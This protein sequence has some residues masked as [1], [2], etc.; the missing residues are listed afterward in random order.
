MEGQYRNFQ[1]IL[2]EELEQIE[3]SF[4]EERTELIDSN[5][6]EIESL[7]SQRRDNE[8]YSLF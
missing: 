4:V 3:K 6:K 1:T 8:R 2:R 5:A 7:F